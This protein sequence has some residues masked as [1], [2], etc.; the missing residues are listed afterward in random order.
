MLFKSKGG[1]AYPLGILTTRGSKLSSKRKKINVS[2]NSKDKSKNIILR[3][4][5]DTSFVYYDED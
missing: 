5:L 1:K 3:K 4:F 2:F